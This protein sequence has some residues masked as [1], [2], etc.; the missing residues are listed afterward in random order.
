M[1]N[2]LSSN[3][4][5]LCSQAVKYYQH[6]P[7]NPP[8]DHALP[9]DLSLVNT[10]DTRF[11]KV[12]FNSVL[13]SEYI[14]QSVLSHHTFLLFFISLIMIFIQSFVISLLIALK[15]QANC[16]NFHSSNSTIFSNDYPPLVHNH[17]LQRNQ[18]KTK[19]AA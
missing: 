8:L 1:D 13:Y 19:V 10:S 17:I 16:S 14:S 12:K 2:Q 4:R 6:Q 11:S 5:Y 7:Q 18:T 9:P 3:S 15:I